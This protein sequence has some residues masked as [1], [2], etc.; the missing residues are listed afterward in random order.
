MSLDPKSL[1]SFVS[2]VRYGSI[3][4]AAASEHLAPSALS[5]RI[6]ELENRV[7]TPLLVRSN[8]GV[9]A[10]SAGRALVDLAHRLLNDLADIEAQ[11]KTFSSGTQGYVSVFAN[12]SAMT[13]F[14]PQDLKHF[15][16]Q[17]PKVQIHLEQKVSTEIIKAVAENE[18]DLGVVVADETSTDLPLLP[19]RSDRLVLITAIEHPLA[20]QAR[21]TLDQTWAY[22]YVGLPAGSQINDRL[23][24]AAHEQG[25]R[26]KCR[27]YVP[28]YDVLQLM[29]EAG[30][31]I[32]VLPESIALGGGHRLCRIAIDESWACR[33][34]SICIR[35]PHALSPSAR[36]LIATMQREAGQS[37][38]G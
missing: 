8:K 13:Q 34:L 38:Q 11:M 27:F 12:I 18:A 25:E 29:V 24:R 23:I 2:A 20:G 22:D 16:K 3:A 5:R 14:L 9:A 26:W 6:S 28:S 35:D 31:G 10:T 32:G 33:A 17:H 4:D 37:A 15:L 30:L 1:R 19:Y 36:L 21:I 7:G